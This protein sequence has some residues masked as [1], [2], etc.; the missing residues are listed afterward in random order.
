[1]TVRKIE[2]GGSPRWVIDI[3]WKTPDGKRR[4][5]RRDAQVNTATAARAEERRLLVELGQKGEIVAV[6][7]KP[8]P[9]DVPENRSFADAVSA[10]QKTKAITHLKPSTRAS[11]TEVLD[12]LL[13][14]RFK[15]C[16]LD[17]ITYTVAAELD[18]DLV[19]SKLAPSTRRNVLVV[20]RSVLRSAVDMQL[21]ER[22]PELPKLPKVGRT[23]LR[24]LSSAQVDELLR[25]APPASRLAFS[26][27][28]YAGLRGGEIRGLTWNDVDLDARTLVVRRAICRGVSAAPKSGHERRVPLAKQLVAL[29]E[30][31]P[32]E[33]RR[34]SA[35]AA[36]TTTGKIWSEAG[37][38]QAFHRAARRAKVVGFRA[39][40][41]RHY[42]VTELF[43]RGASAPAV[44][45][46][47]G[48]QDL[49]TTQRY[50]HMAQNDLRATIARLERGNALE[51]TPAASK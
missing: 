50:A 38:H 11:Y 22:M 40:D 31:V 6:A 3:L 48:H 43:R 39:H 33:K 8:P 44:Q 47:A 42:F 45:A 27:A 5:Y 18:A 1:M 24:V 30:E 4:R 25:V 17:A 10:F 29:L 23:I 20:L 9:T 35:A 14:P 28:A 51:T 46:L 41:L 32:K 34:S 36:P 21:L 49:S 37:L 13:M 12:R 15:G 2:R 26:L 19:R 16:D 7:P